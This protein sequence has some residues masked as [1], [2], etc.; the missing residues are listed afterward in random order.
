MF[1]RLKAL[2][3]K[4]LTKIENFDDDTAKKKAYINERNIEF[5][6]NL[7]EKINSSQDRINSIRKSIQNTKL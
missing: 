1:K 5:S 7:H 6:N 3:S 4:Q 2:Y